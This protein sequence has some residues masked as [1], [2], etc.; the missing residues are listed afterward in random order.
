MDILSHIQQLNKQ[1]KYDKVLDIDESLSDDK[2]TPEIDHQIVLAIL[3]AIKD[4]EPAAVKLLLM[5]AVEL[6]E[7]HVDNFAEDQDRNYILGVIYS[8]LD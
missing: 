2:R 6:S 7:K 3:E 1:G 4:E 8:A 5:R